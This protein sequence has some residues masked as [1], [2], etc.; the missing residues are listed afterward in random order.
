MFEAVRKHQRLMLALILLLI[1]PAFVFFGLSG[2]DSMVGGG[3]DVAVV[4]GTKIP[5]NAF[6]EAHRQQVE[7]VQ[8]ML[9]GQVDAKMF[10]TPAARA[11]TLESLITQQAILSEARSKYI[12]VPPAQVQKAILGIDVWEH[13]YYLK[14]QNRRPD[15]LGAWWNVV[16]WDE[17]N[18]LLKG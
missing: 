9:G 14:Y 13:A 3:N 8:Q 5:R 6:D 2:Y 4:D 10:D 7:R 18:R 11:Q 17:V 1:F 15:Y 16:N 12:S